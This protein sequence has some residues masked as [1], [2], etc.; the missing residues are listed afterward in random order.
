MP[1][2]SKL[3]VNF[4]PDWL[5]RRNQEGTVSP[6]FHEVMFTRNVTKS[7]NKKFFVLHKKQPR[8]VYQYIICSLERVFK[9][10]IN[11]RVNFLC[12][13]DV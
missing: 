5:S 11:C 6:T 13:D 4:R 10:N 12:F 9:L 7:V 2:L 8:P 1:A 3:Q